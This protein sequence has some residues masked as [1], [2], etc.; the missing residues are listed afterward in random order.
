MLTNNQSNFVELHSQEVI[1]ALLFHELA[2]VQRYNVP[3][4]LLRLKIAASQQTKLQEADAIKRII[5]QT[6]KVQLRQVDVAGQYQND[7]LIVLPVTDEAGAAV[8]ARRLVTTLYG[9]HPYRYGKNLQINP[10]I[11]IAAVAPKI[12]ISIEEFVEQATAALREAYT[13]SPGAIVG[14][15]EVAPFTPESLPEPGTPSPQ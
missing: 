9:V 15:S 4:A 11:G 1:W 13:R 14:Y 12:I 2:R 7:Y 6:L 10:F 3:L 5:I 8:A